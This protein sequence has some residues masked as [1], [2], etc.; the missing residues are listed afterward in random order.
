MRRGSAAASCNFNRDEIFFK[1]PL[2]IQMRSA[3]IT[4]SSDKE[5]A[6]KGILSAVFV[7][8]KE[9]KSDKGVVRSRYQT[10]APEDPCR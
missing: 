5:A 10:E 1:N 3:K 4:T 2:T 6:D 9:I 7:V 8:F